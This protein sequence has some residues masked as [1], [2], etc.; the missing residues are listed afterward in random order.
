MNKRWRVTKTKSKLR[1][2]AWRV[3]QKRKTGKIF[4]D[5]ESAVT[6]AICMFE[7]DSRTEGLSR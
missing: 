4:T 5:W 6:Y 1:W 7:C 3:R 2:V